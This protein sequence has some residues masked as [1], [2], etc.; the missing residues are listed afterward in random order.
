VLLIYVSSM[1]IFLYHII[2]FVAF[3][4]V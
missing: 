4:M 3:E 1:G 2:L